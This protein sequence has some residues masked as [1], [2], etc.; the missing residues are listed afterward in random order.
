MAVATQ[1]LRRITLRMPSRLHE[2][3]T[4]AAAHR[5]LSLN[6]VALEALETYVAQEN[7]RLPLRELSEALAPAASAEGLTEEEL[8]LH[9][10]EARPR[11]WRERYQDMVGA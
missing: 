7:Q 9:V 4:E 5:D 8:L 10:K 11:I 2:A 1:D 6:T 3:L